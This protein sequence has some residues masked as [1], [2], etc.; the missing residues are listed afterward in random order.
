MR[1]EDV[2]S[3]PR[4]VFA[5]VFGRTSEGEHA[6]M[7]S[8]LN[9]C[10]RVTVPIARL[11]SAAA[12]GWALVSGAHLLAVSHGPSHV[13]AA[14]TRGIAFAP[15]AENPTLDCGTLTVPVDYRRPH[16][17]TVELAIIRAR[18]TNAA[19]RIG[20]IV[21]NPGGPGVSGVDFVLRVV[22]LPVAARLREHFDVVSFDPRGVGRSREVRCTLEASPIPDDADD[23]TLI[24]LFDEFSERYARACLEQN[25][26]FVAH[27]GT[28]NTARDV[29]MLRLALGER[30]ITYAAGS[31]GTVL[32]AA[33]AS[34]F[35]SR[36]RAMMLDGGFPPDFRDYLMEDWAEMSG[37][38]ETSFQR[39]DQLCR[40]DP[41]CALTSLGV[42]AAFDEIAARL[43]AAPVSSPT[44][45]LLTT[46]ALQDVVATL[47]DFETLWPTIVDALAA[48][49]SGDYSPL[50]A[51]LPVLEGQSYPAL[52]AIRCNDYGTRKSAA[53]YLPFD[54]AIGALHPRFFGRFFIANFTAPC[55]AWPAAEPVQIRDVHRLVRTPIMIVAN[56]FDSRTPMAH[57]RRLA[58]ALGVER[59]VLRYAGGGH[60]AFF[61]T[62]ACVE[63]AVLEYLVDLRLPRKGFTCPGQPVTFESTSMR[64]RGINPTA[65]LRQPGFVSRLPRLRR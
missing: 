55:M 40:R 7:G 54:E 48:A 9:R 14:V 4:L 51:L 25:G 36:V 27:V 57:A 53:D 29:E 61:S 3:R 64:D 44:G 18:A 56:D 45:A 2:P 43:A 15:C 19:N 62:T 8:M 47:I 49:R 22:R 30:Q 23:A 46:A 42:V 50:F 6:F 17:D 34:M 10:L 38:F 52:F 12:V 31:Y 13:P 58:R 41:A 59:H 65:V 11:S 28:M 5:H 63:D 24:R 39:L 1:S 32:G 35:P 33:Y 37:A 20:V 60:T 21:G 26:S 16:G